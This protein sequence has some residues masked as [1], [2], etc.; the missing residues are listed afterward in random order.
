M[1]PP[2]RAPG[3]PG[4]GHG[5]RIGEDEKKKGATIE[6]KPQIKNMIGEATR[7]M[8][9]A[10]KVRREVKDSK[11]RII[12]APG[13]CGFTNIYGHQ[14]RKQRLKVIPCLKSPCLCFI[15][16]SLKPY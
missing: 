6:A 11:G 14:S 16:A 15:C 7:F 5:G 8:P 1:K 4:L 13:T 9:T 2:R 3:G 10:L 12:K